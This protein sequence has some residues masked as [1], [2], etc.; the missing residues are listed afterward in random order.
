MSK[1]KKPEH[2]QDAEQC[3]EAGECLREM[4]APGFTEA[5]P[6]AEVATLLS[7]LEGYGFECEAGPLRLCTQWQELRRLVEGEPQ[8]ATLA[9]FKALNA[10]A[11]RAAAVAGAKDHPNPDAAMLECYADSYTRM[12]VEARVLAADVA[13]DIRKNMIPALRL[14]SSATTPSKAVPEVG[15]LVESKIGTYRTIEGGLPV[16]TTDP[17]KAIRF[18]RR[19]DAEMFAAEDEAAWRIAEHVWG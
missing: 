6:S 5:A 10:A 16:W 8:E 11:D 7:Q 17:N 2:C 4:R 1:C 12:G 15:W 19:A 13:M 14:A 9:E 18:A 3:A